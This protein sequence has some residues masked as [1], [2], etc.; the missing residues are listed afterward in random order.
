M[1]LFSLF[2]PKSTNIQK[3]YNF[4]Y[5]MIRWLGTSQNVNIFYIYTELLYA[6]ALSVQKSCMNRTIYENS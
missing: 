2:A 1:N 3:T 6:F 4:Q 5:Y